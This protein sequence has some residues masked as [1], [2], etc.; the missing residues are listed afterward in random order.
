MVSIAVISIGRTLVHSGQ[1]LSVSVSGKGIGLFQFDSIKG[2]AP[3]IHKHFI[4]VE[5][6]IVF[7]LLFAIFYGIYRLLC[8]KE[9]L[10]WIWVGVRVIALVLALFYAGRLCLCILHGY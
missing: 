1:W 3:F 10:R 2:F 9:L 4:I 7:V 6:L 5:Q 8:Q